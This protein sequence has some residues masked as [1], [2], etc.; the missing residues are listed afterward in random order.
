MKV[1]KVVVTD[2][3]KDSDIKRI[4]WY[5]DDQR[6]ALQLDLPQAEVDPLLLLLLPLLCV[7]LPRNTTSRYCC[8]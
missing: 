5:G 3:S 7:D 1:S 8:F 2:T 4:R 6:S